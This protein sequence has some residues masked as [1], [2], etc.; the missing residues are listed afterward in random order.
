VKRARMVEAA[1]S[2]RSVAHWGKRRA[3]ESSVG[4]GSM[5]MSSSKTRLANWAMGMAR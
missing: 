3:R 5:A 2:T 1:M 4:S